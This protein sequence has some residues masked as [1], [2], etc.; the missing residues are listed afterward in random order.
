M[1]KQ[2]YMY[3]ETSYSFLTELYMCQEKL[4]VGFYLLEESSMSSQRGSKVLEYNGRHIHN[5]SKQYKCWKFWQEDRMYSVTKGLQNFKHS[6]YTFYDKL[7]LQ[8]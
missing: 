1:G 8:D 5:K 2:L 4:S 3:K 6:F 7:Q